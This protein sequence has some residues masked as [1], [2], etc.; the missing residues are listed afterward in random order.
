MKAPGTDGHRREDGRGR[1]EKRV[2]SGRAR[3][4][5]DLPGPRYG[6][7]LLRQVPAAILSQSVAAGSKSSNSRFQASQLTGRQPGIRDLLTP[8]LYLSGGKGGLKSDVLGLRDRAGVRALLG[9]CRLRP[10]QATP[11]DHFSKLYAD[12]VSPSVSA[13]IVETNLISGEEDAQPF[14]KKFGLSETVGRWLSMG[15]R[16]VTYVYLTLRRQ[17][18]R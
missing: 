4:F 15:Y 10:R 2:W 9:S 1:G 5:Y 3:S 6:V 12:Y 7:Y 14:C 17:P 8:V 13:S 18:Y 11:S 16:H